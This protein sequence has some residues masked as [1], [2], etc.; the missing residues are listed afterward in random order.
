MPAARS[1]KTNTPETVPTLSNPQERKRVLNVLAQRRYRQRRKEKIAVLEAQS[2]CAGLGTDAGEAAPRE[3]QLQFECHETTV[4]ELPQMQSSIV[5]SLDQQAALGDTDLLAFEY[6][7]FDM[8][9]AQRDSF[10]NLPTPLPS[11]AFISPPPQFPLTADGEILSI[12]MLSATRAFATVAIAFNVTTHIWDPYYLHV[13]PRLTPAVAS[14]PANL[15]PVA[16]QLTIPH[17]PFIDLLPWPSVREKLICI[18]SMPSALRPLVA[19][20]EDGGEMT[21]DT[22]DETITAQAQSAFGPGVRQS[23]AIVQ[24]VQDLDDLQDG[25]GIRVHGNT[26]SWGEG[27]EL[28]EDAWEIGDLFYRKW[29]WCLDQRIVESSNRRRKERGISRLTMIG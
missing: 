15:H 2:S 20:E 10:P 27:N 8:S 11:T 17:H 3:L 16:A 25:G 19:Q 7:L 23:K 24:L 13:V 22:L 28:V 5:D 18:L 4:Q 12:P 1:K 6:D 14:L 29:W 21:T 9:L 26:T